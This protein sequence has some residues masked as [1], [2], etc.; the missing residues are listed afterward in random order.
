[1]I[2]PDVNLLVYAFNRSDPQHKAAKTW[3]EETL[4][5]DTPVG[6]PWIVSAGFIRVMTHPRVLLEP[7]A[8]GDAARHVRA[9]LLQPCV[10]VTE[11]GRKF[12]GLF[13]GYLERLGAA[14]NLTTDAQLAAL[15]VENQAEL[16]SAD[17][18]FSRFEGL[19]WRN[20]LR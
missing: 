15:T 18:D 2:I 5:G 9:W 8:A 11:P 3:W 12:E 16:H 6:L 1:M 10:V 13:L 4:N 14:G 20:P 19:R 7:M 17:A